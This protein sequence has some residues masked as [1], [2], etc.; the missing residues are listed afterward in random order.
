M[1]EE[2]QT[3]N[4][5]GTFSLIVGGC[6]EFIGVTCMN[7]TSSRAHDKWMTK[8]TF[9][10]SGELDTLRSQLGDGLGPDLG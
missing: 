4:M 9:D 1:G 2:Q 7:C 10:F 3:K 6:T 8:K 5:K